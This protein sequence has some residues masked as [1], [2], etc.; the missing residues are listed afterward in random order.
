MGEPKSRLST[1]S[2]GLGSSVDLIVLWV[3]YSS[4]LSSELNLRKVYKVQEAHRTYREQEAQKDTKFIRW[5]HLQKSTPI[6]GGLF[7]GAAAL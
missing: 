6:L 1:A 3:P 7:S 2:S 4:A 5:M